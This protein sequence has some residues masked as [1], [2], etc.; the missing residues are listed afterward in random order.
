MSPVLISTLVAAVALIAGVLLGWFL[1]TRA[2]PDDSRVEDEL[3][4]QITGLERRMGEFQT[5][6]REA[7]ERRVRAEA[8][9]EALKR[10][11]PALE[12]QHQR[13]L[14][15]RDAFHRRQQEELKEGH[16][17]ALVELRNSHDRALADLKES[18]KAL[19]ADALKEN[20]PAFLALAQENLG[21]LQAEAKGDLDMRKK[22]IEALLKPLQEQLTGYQALSLQSQQTI[23]EVVQ[24]LN[25]MKR[26]NELLASETSRFRMVLKSSQARGKWG[27][28]TLRRV[29]EA[30]GMSAHVDFD[31]QVSEGDSRPDMV[32]KLP[33]GRSIIVDAKVPDLDF[34]E[35]LDS[36]DAEQRSQKLRDHAQKLKQTIRELAARNYPQKFA[37]SLDYVVLFLPA[38]SLFSAALEGDQDLLLWAAQQRIMIATPASLIALLR[39][40]S[41]SWQHYAQTQNTR[42]IADTAR[43]LYQRVAVFYGH[44]QGIGDA[45]GR[46]SQA[47]NRAVASYDSRVRPTGERLMELKVDDAGKELPAIDT[48]EEN[49]RL[50][51]P[52]DTAYRP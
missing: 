5:A 11:F 50:P 24:Q 39:S 7:G 44:F 3:R 19:S 25:D 17:R 40:V 38:E 21:R 9:A 37:N 29:V 35:A 33:E 42:L 27:E 52:A 15:E 14:A 34:I 45:M 26:T 22:E 32:V 36:A 1:G 51:N 47:F 18:F 12:E 8:D 48:V 10:Q 41:M 20:T 6:A 43:E 46:A 4:M 23:G 13:Q 28:E 31:V 49:L 16:A 2:K 30:A